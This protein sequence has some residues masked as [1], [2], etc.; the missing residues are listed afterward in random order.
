METEE[1]HEINM[2]LSVDKIVSVNAAYSSKVIFVNGKPTSTIYKTREAKLTE[3]Y[4]KEQVRLLDIPKNYPWVNDKTLF[5]YSINVIFKN[6]FLSKD[7]DNTI[8]LVQDGIFRALGINDSHVVKIY[9]QK[10]YC[11][12]ISDEKIC[13]SLREVNNEKELNLLYLPKP[14]I[15]WT[16]WDKKEDLGL[17][18]L[19]KRK[20]KN[21]L[22]LTNDKVGKADTKLFVIESDKINYNTF[23]DIALDI[24]SNVFHSSGLAYIAFIGE[25]ADTLEFQKRLND[26]AQSYSGIRYK[27][28]KDANDILEWLKE[29]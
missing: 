20:M 10:S 6:G 25:N 17:K 28:V 9:A 29:G 27:N 26:L 3:A 15:I 19:G 13:V 24:C 22:Y 5:T 16:D 23:S 14:E 21:T 18:E 1:K 4:I 8:K 7:L 12:G 2:V 11:P